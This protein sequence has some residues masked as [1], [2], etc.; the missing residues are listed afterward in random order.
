MQANRAAVLAI[1]G[2][3]GAIGVGGCVPTVLT[4]YGYDSHTAYYYAAAPAYYDPYAAY[5]HG[6]ELPA[7]GGDGGQGL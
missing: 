5:S 2:L 7:G 6:Y 4:A 3:V 1:V